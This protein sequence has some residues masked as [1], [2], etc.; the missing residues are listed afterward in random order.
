MC[1]PG[2]AS[3]DKSDLIR[4]ARLKEYMYL[5]SPY[6]IADLKALDVQLF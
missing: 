4:E 1:H 6:F 3:Q 5:S 2:L